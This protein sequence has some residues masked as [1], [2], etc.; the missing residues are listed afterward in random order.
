MVRLGK[1]ACSFATLATNFQL[2]VLPLPLFCFINL[3]FLFS[4]FTKQGRFCICPLLFYSL[5]PSLNKWSSVFHLGPNAL[6]LNLWSWVLLG[7]YCSYQTSW[8]SNGLSPLEQKLELSLNSL[9]FSFPLVS[10]RRIHWPSFNCIILQP[11]FNYFMYLWNF[12][13]YNFSH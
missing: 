11:N 2:L 5:F 13:L 4:I 12:F 1:H 10:F 9:C 8:F 6:I 7:F 3:H